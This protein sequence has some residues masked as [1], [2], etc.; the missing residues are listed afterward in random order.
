MK[1]IRLWVLLISF[2]IS[3]VIIPT[4]TSNII[5]STP[6]FL[7]NINIKDIE[8]STE[9]GGGYIMNIDTPY[10]WVEISKT[11][12]HLEISNSNDDYEEISFIGGWN[13]TFYGTEY[14]KIFVSTNGWM[15][16]T[17]LGD[18]SYKIYKIP[19]TN[20]ENYDCVALLC[21]DLDPSARGY[22]Y[23][24]FL[25]TAPNRYLV[26]EYYNMVQFYSEEFIGDF[27]VIFYETGNIKFQYKNV[28]N[29]GFLYH[30]IGLDHGDLTN[31][32]FYDLPLPLSSKTIEFTFD[33]MVEV[34]FSLNFSVNYEY[35]WVI[36][37]LNNAKMETIFGTDWEQSYG[38]L[39]NP[40]RYHKTKINISSI[41][42]N[43][44]HW[45]INFTMWD[46]VHI[47]EDHSSISNGNDSIIYRL[48][49]REYPND[50]YLPN[51]FPLFLPIPT[52]KYLKFARLSSHYSWI[53]LDSDDNFTHLNYDDYKIINGDR[54]GIQGCAIYNLN[55]FLRK[56]HFRIH[57][58]TSSENIIIF[59]MEIFSSNFLT[60]YTLGV[61]L[62]NEYSWILSDINDTLMETFFG[63]NWEQ[64]FG[65]SSDPIEF[66]KTKI[67]ITSIIENST[68]WNIKY[69]IWDWIGI[70]NDFSSISNREDSMLYRVNPFNYTHIH[71][72]ANI[73]PLFIPSPSEL[74]LRFAYLN[75]SFYNNILFDP[76][77]NSTKIDIN[78]NIGNLY[79]DCTAAYNAKGILKYIE[80]NINPYY[81]PISEMA[82]IFKMV[83]FFDG[84]KPPYVGIN[85]SDVYEYGVF[86]C[87][88]NDPPS[89][90][91]YEDSFDL[92]RIK[93][94]IKF[95]DGGD[96]VL[97]R[98][99]VFTKIYKMITDGEW[100]ETFSFSPYIMPLYSNLL[101]IYENYTSDIIQYSFFSFIV[102][103]NINWTNYILTL[104]EAIDSEQSYGINITTINNGYKMSYL[105]EG[106]TSEMSCT[107]TP[108]GVL[109]VF[110]WSYKGKEFFTYRLND[111]DYV[112]PGCEDPFVIIP[113]IIG[114]IITSSMLV[115]LTVLYWQF[116]RKVR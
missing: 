68:Y 23:Y 49:P 24:Q 88:N 36:V 89:N 112:I 93:I 16:F 3:L 108:Y 83:N 84:P 87:P 26:I 107:Y 12:M 42:K 13:F 63:A 102:R 85:V 25:G 31:Y 71:N 86:F 59:E 41:D 90:F 21:T 76:F 116:K 18:T 56:L 111:F 64:N 91:Y 70:E 99:T 4:K 50:H 45:E 48:D 17:N 14:D 92:K 37:N 10:S 40:M 96:P 54:L 30:I 109:D 52:Y 47:L 43:S 34:S 82:T 81:D 66:S 114:I 98:V 22:I 104:K 6:E 2:I 20:L 65:F 15:S 62:N 100:T 110:S 80:F 103:N 58:Y 11:G 7:K 113:G 105:I 33:E 75:R 53:Y 35:S 115:G 55:G 19:E 78:L 9:S 44:T 69:S 60:D 27:E 5:I 106:N 97:K 101:Y 57:N 29:V 28:N 46:W 32:N 73:F 72:L 1:K 74:Y 61:E 51:I 39:S 38:L 67:K 95:I 79:L 77:D 8:I 94:E